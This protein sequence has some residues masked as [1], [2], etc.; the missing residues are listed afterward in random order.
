MLAGRVEI[1][2]SELAEG[3]AEC[4]PVVD[5][6]C[7]AQVLDVAPYGAFAEVQPGRDGNIGVP[8]RGLR[9]DLALPVGECLDFAY[10]CRS[11]PNR[12]NH[13]DSSPVW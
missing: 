5:S 10:W 2:Q 7:V 11:C 13:P 12:I 3:D 1:D 6:E 8:G 4:E 9:E